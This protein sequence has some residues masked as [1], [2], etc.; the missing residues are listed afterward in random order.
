[1]VAHVTIAGVVLIL[2]FAVVSGVLA[3]DVGDSL[4]AR[5]FERLAS[6]TA[7]GL[8]PAV[9]TDPT[10][11]PTATGD[12]GRQVA[13]VL[14]AGPVAAVSVRDAS[15]RVLWSVRAEMIGRVT[16][17]PADARRA[18]DTGS[19]VTVGHPGTAVHVAHAGIRDVHGTPVLLDLAGNRDDVRPFARQAWLALAPAALIALLLLVLVQ[20]PLTWRLAARVRR[21]QDDDQALLR[22]VL[23][24]PDAERRRLAGELHDSVLPVLS[25]VAM[26]LDA[27]RL[28]AGPGAESEARLPPMAATAVRQAIDELR[29]LVS[30]P[31][32]APEPLPDL[33]DRLRSLAAEQ[34]DA[35]LQVSVRTS[36]ISGLPDTVTGLLYRAA[37]EALRNAA[38]HSQATSAEVTVSRDG[39]TVTLVVDDDGCGFDAQRLAERRREGHVGLDTLGDVVVHA[40]GTLTANSSPGQ[41]T[42]L[43]VTVPVDVPVGAQ[44]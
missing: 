12:L 2:A 31:G 21:R 3:R 13:G 34:Q 5:A 22:T 37:R 17:L 38:T 7:A 16:P 6:V 14:D 28:R 19:V 1:M 41:G 32:A 4:S 8:A 15:G 35:G 11:P 25:G 24:A 27:A 23:A 9:D 39:R 42:R 18:L 40:G 20:L 29:A 30:H 26:E 36:G 10:R 33:A 43:V 44:P